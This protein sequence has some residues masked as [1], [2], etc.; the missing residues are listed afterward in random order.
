MTPEPIREETKGPQPLSVAHEAALFDHLS[1]TTGPERVMPVLV[2]DHATGLDYTWISPQ[3]MVQMPG[4]FVIDMKMAY[5]DSYD[6]YCASRQTDVDFQT[7]R[8]SAQIEALGFIQSFAGFELHE[9]PTTHALILVGPC[10]FTSK[11]GDRCIDLFSE[12]FE[13]GALDSS[14]PLLRRRLIP[15]DTV[16]SHLAASLDPVMRLHEA[17]MAHYPHYTPIRTSDVHWMARGMYKSAVLPPKNK[18]P[19]ADAN[20]ARR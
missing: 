12:D 14:I 2:L 10:T 19:R 8:I 4:L 15:G 13:T 6:M 7:F 5:Q 3:L 18:A 11:H 1:V 20:L 16:I 17:V 9:R